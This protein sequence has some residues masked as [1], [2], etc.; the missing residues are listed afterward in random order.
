[1]T[2]LSTAMVS[3]APSVIYKGCTS[4]KKLIPTSHC[5]HVSF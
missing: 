2:A 3:Y 5:N 4:G 1:M